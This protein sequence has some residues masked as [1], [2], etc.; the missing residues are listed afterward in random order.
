MKRL[1]ESL[2]K[3][4]ILLAPLRGH[5]IQPAERKQ[6][7]SPKVSI[8]LDT[9]LLGLFWTLLIVLYVEDNIQDDGESKTST[10][11]LYNIHHR[12]IPFKSIYLDVNRN[13]CELHVDSN[14]ERAH[15]AE[16]ETE[17]NHDST[18]LITVVGIDQPLRM[19]V[20]TWVQI[21]ALKRGLILD[22]VP[23]CT[24]KQYE[25]SGI[26]LGMIKTLGSVNLTLHDCTYRIQVAPE[27]IQL[28][29]DGLIGRDI[30][31]NSVIHYREG[32]VDI[33]GYRYLP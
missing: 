3:L 6:L 4:G 22:N 28:T 8:Y 20:D 18:V 27:E 29:E 14:S 12:Q 19:L 5:V 1:S 31:K 24:D 2:Y 26:S 11:A 23:I 32:Y 33:S 10:I 30:L 25:I 7:P 9:E 17:K 21:S 16:C 13:A 15:A